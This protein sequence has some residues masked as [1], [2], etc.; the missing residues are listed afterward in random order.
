MRYLLLLRLMG[1]LLFS[2]WGLIFPKYIPDGGVGNQILV[3]RAFSSPGGEFPRIIPPPPG[4]ARRSGIVR[5]VLV[6]PQRSGV[7]SQLP[8][9]YRMCRFSPLGRYPKV[10][11][12]H[13]ITPG[14][15]LMISWGIC[16]GSPNILGANIC[17]AIA[18]ISV[19]NFPRLVQRL[20]F[21]TSWLLLRYRLERE[22]TEY[23][24][25]STPR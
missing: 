10:R 3:I 21:L 24:E 23:C 12:P 16:G 8:K 6:A 18:S 1:Y 25:I 17:L 7:A 14:S 13:G 2:G 5:A 15:I 9:D 20:N 4:D 22:S 11:P 19:G